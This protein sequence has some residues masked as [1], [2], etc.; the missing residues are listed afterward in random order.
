MAAS[1]RT[2][3]QRVNAAN[4]TLESQ[5]AQAAYVAQQPDATETQKESYAAL[6]RSSGAKLEPSTRYLEAVRILV[7]A[8]AA[9]VK[10]QDQH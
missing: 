4:G 8:I 2:A 10:A 3:Q 7:D 5:L 1:L 9:D 6:S